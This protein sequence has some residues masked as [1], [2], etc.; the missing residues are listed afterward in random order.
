MRFTI[1]HLGSKTPPKPVIPGKIFVIGRDEQADI[2]LTQGS[3][4]I[5]KRH[6]EI[7]LRGEA[8]LVRG[9]GVAGVSVNGVKMGPQTSVRIG[10][11]IQIANNIL[12]V[13]REQTDQSLAGPVKTAP[14]PLRANLPKL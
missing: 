8:L 2:P 9:I 1:K 3:F 5:S 6:C 11:Q 13:G 7:E 10:D 4:V 14:A 12:L